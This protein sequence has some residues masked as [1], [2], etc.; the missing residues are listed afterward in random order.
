MEVLIFAVVGLLFT[1]VF[2]ALTG[3]PFFLA[4]RLGLRAGSVTGRGYLR[5]LLPLVL[6]LGFA[7][8]GAGSYATFRRGCQHMDQSI[9][10]LAPPVSSPGIAIY[11]DRSTF[12][13]TTFSWHR[14]I[15]IGLVQFVDVEGRRHCA[16]QKA[17]ERTPDF[18]IAISCNQH[19]AARSGIAVHVLPAKPVVHW[20]APPIHEAVIEVRDSA[21]GTVIARATD[22][23]FGGGLTSWYLSFVGRDQDYRHL[24]C[25]YASQQSGP[26]R[27]S[28]TSR[29][30]F[31][32]YQQAD[33]KLLSSALR[34]P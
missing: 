9:A 17:H 29:P 16:G 22:L 28:L 15:E 33:M 10:L 6:L 1:A 4:E 18:P 31:A 26:W 2:L 25:G 5:W 14:A 11:G 27:P 3:L 23:V 7:A 12:T 32:E 34:Q 20:W 19:T 8:W 24:S 13:G 21:S 30:R